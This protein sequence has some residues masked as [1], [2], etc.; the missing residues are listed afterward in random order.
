MALPAPAVTPAPPVLALNVP[1]GFRA[2]EFDGTGYLLDPPEV[3]ALHDILL[4][5]LKTLGVDVKSRADVEKILCLDA[6]VPESAVLELRRQVLQD[7][8]LAGEAGE[9]LR[10]YTPGALG[11]GAA[12]RDAK[13]LRVQLPMLA[14]P[15][16]IRKRLLATIRKDLHRHSNA[17]KQTLLKPGVGLD[18]E[19][20][21]NLFIPR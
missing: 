21:P 1:T 14:A 2:D 8:A 12:D 17:I 3:E 4:A 7:P 9:A 10:H 5:H 20:R 11:K 15:A 6:E 18:E 13:L 16:S 19:G